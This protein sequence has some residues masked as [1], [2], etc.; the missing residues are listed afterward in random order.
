MGNPPVKSPRKTM[1]T[2]KD[3]NCLLD[4]LIRAEVPSNGSWRSHRALQ[5]ESHEE[6]RFTIPAGRPRISWR[7]S[8]SSL[9]SLFSRMRAARKTSPLGMATPG[10]SLPLACRHHVGRHRRVPHPL[11]V[12]RLRPFLFIVFYYMVFDVCSVHCVYFCTSSYWAY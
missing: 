8:S 3:S 11:W 6:L 1:K 12:W 9:R 5:L 7:T 10:A 4:Q 2:A